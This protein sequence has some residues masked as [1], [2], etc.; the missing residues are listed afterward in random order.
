[1]KYFDSVSEVIE[2]GIEQYLSNHEFK[3]SDMRN[4]VRKAMEAVLSDMGITAKTR[5]FDFKLTE[6]CGLTLL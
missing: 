1:M 3:L 5:I 4:K 6:K 2:E